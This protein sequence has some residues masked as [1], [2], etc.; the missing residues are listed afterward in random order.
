MGGASPSLSWVTSVQLKVL[1]AVAMGV[2]W[3]SSSEMFLLG[4]VDPILSSPPS[5]F[6]GVAGSVNQMCCSCCTSCWHFLLLLRSVLFFNLFLGVVK[7]ALG[8]VAGIFFLLGL[9][10]TADPPNLG[11]A[12]AAVLTSLI[13]S[14]VESECVT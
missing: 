11:M 6:L 13:F 2:S 12:G 7:F 14:K 8:T 4:I 3:P 9:F 1:L 10:S 5:K